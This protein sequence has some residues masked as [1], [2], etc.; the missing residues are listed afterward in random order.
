M[1]L[2]FLIPILIYSL[3]SVFIVYKSNANNRFALSILSS[4]SLMIFYFF[5]T[6]YNDKIYLVNSEL[7]YLA[8]LNLIINGLVINFLFYKLENFIFYLENFI[9]NNGNKIAITNIG[10][11]LIFLFL[12]LS[13]GNST[14]AGSVFFIIALNILYLFLCLY[15][16]YILDDI[17]YKS[18]NRKNFNLIFKNSPDTISDVNFKYLTENFDIKGFQF[19]H[20]YKNMNINLEFHKKDSTNEEPLFIAV[21]DNVDSDIL[22]NKNYWWNI[23]LNKK[24][25]CFK[26]FGISDSDFYLPLNKGKYIQLNTH[27]DFKDA[28]L[29]ENLE[30]QINLIKVIEY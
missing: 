30:N 15:I 3:F 21:L 29:K 22:Y 10:F 14:S 6:L 23:L 12:Y 20:L 19:L 8:I 7:T 28:N 1:E 11:P 17:F 5:I 27:I 9:D 26:Y 13:I 4:I 18:L 16:P 2:E 24:S 25:V